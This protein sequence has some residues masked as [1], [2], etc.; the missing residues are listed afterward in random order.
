MVIKLLHD[1]DDKDPAV[2]SAFDDILKSLQFTKSQKKQT[3]AKDK[4]GKF[5]AQVLAPPQGAAPAPAPA[6]EPAPAPPEEEDREQLF[7]NIVEQ[8]KNV[9][10]LLILFDDSTKYTK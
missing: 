6:P 9:F 8:I 5:V 1:I 3:K 2:K 10:S 4:K 7:K